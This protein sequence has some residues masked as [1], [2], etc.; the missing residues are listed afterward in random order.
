MSEN[1]EKSW[2]ERVFARKSASSGVFGALGTR[3]AAKSLARIADSAELVAEALTIIVKREYGADLGVKPGPRERRMEILE[4]MWPNDEREAIR[5][6]VEALREA[7][8]DD[9][10]AGG[11]VRL[12]GGAASGEDELTVEERAFL[13]ELD[14]KGGA[15]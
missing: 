10:S 15:E 7:E 6:H 8:M 3:S 5:E 11:G 14:G 12:Q 2:I 1:S 4:P 13:A 9:G